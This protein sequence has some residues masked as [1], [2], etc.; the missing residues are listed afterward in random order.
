MNGNQYI[1]EVNNMSLDNE[2]LMVNESLFHTANG[3]LGVR[4]N[5]EEGYPA[6][7]DSIQGQY[8][9]GYYDTD[10]IEYGEKLYGFPE[11]KQTIVNVVDTQG[12]RL[13]IGGEEFSM[14]DGKVL[15]SSRKMDM[16]RGLYQRS[17]HWISPNGHEL[18]ILITRMASF[19][20][21]P[22]FLIDYRVKSINF[23]GDVKF[24][25]THSG[26]VE[27][28]C[29]PNDP[30]VSATAVQHI[31]KQ[32][33]EFYGDVSVIRVKAAHSG[34]ELT[35]AVKNRLSVSCKV[36]R[37]VMEDVLKEGLTA[38][39]QAGDELRLLKYTVLCDERRYPST[40][41]SALHILDKV[42]AVPVEKL[43]DDQKNYLKR[44]WGK[45]SVE[46]DGN[47]E[48]A[49]ALCYSLYQLLQAVGKDS[50]SNIAAKGL[51]G[52]GYEGH[53]FWDTEIYMLPF[54]I[55]TQRE[56]AKSLIGCRYAFLPAARKQAKLLGHKKGALYPWRTISGEECSGYF[57]SGS[58]QYHINGDI[59]YTVVAYYLMTKDFDFIAEKGAEIVFETARLWQDVGNY[60]DGIFHI[61]DV[62]GPDEYTC[63]VD[64]NYYTNS[65]A[66]YNLIWAV[67]FYCMLKEHNRTEIIQKIGL[68][69]EEITEFQR[70]ADH[71]YYTYDEK[72]DINPQDNSFLAKE[73]WDIPATPKENFPLLLH[74]HPLYIYRHQ[75]CKQADTVLSHFLLED[76]QEYSTIKNSYEYYEQLTTHDSSL[77]TCIFSIMASKLGMEEKAY[78]YFCQTSMLDIKNTHHNTKDGI[79]TASMGGTYMSIVYGFAGFR[80]KESGIWFAPFLPKDWSVYR[81]Q[82]HYEDSLIC[83]YVTENL[84]KFTLKSGTPKKL[85]VYG[86]PYRL[87]EHLIVEHRKKE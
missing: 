16:E 36:E 75:V 77:S 46:I 3:Y 59:T 42:T 62:T 35:S 7:Y 44:F 53:Y 17:V 39:V 50:V 31:I 41:E 22:L 78:N 54:F 32:E 43:Y 24:I 45:S 38:Q 70:A 64:D 56:T 82:I 2:T 30:R 69:E 76:E 9:N 74:Y 87:E 12:I 72:L 48:L 71:M 1:Y 52:E 28:Y 21:L 49:K 83:V 34:L 11:E 8:I 20:V 67:K 86:K 85:F 18:E 26:N 5:Y 4:A 14:F 65:I 79:H 10:K 25:S 27:N 6:G 40:P 55:L 73:K 23:S 33:A 80:L 47:K 58:A 60:V 13:S 37:A 29:N 61:N 68:Q 51:S 84:C 63:L 66:K 15:T 57:P 81:F 19:T